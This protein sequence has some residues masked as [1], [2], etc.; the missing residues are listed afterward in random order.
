[1]SRI[2]VGIGMEFLKRRCI[3]AA[4][5]GTDAGYKAVAEAGQFKSI[6]MLLQ[7][8]LLVDVIWR[9]YLGNCLQ[10]S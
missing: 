8:R 3:H 6:H 10:Q 5:A 4:G 7:K 1:M 2:L 9:D